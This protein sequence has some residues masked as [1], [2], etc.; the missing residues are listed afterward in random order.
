MILLD[1]TTKSLQ[2]ILGGAVTTT[3]LPIVAAYADV[4]QT[5][6]AVSAISETDTATTGGTAVTAVAAPSASTSRKVALVTVYN[7]D[8]VS[9]AVTV[10]VNNNGTFRIL[11]KATLAVGSTL[12]YADGA[13]WSVTDST[14]AVLSALS[15]DHGALSGLSDDDHTQYLLANGTRALTANWDVGSFEVRAQTLQSDVATG[16]APLIVASTTKVTNLNVDLLDDQSGA[17]YLDAANF[18]GTNW[19]DLTD[20]GATTLHKHDHGGS[21]GLADDDHTQYALLAGRSGGQTITGGTASGDDITIRSTTNATKGDIFLADQGGNVIIGGGATAS[22]V[23]LLEASGSGTNYTA[24]KTQPQ[25][26]N[27]TYTLP[28]D[29]GDASQ[30]LSTDG[31]G[32]LDWVTP[33]SG[34]MEQIFRGL[35]LRTSPNADVAA[36]T[37]AL[38]RCDAMTLDDGTYVEDWDDL[39]AII[40]GSGAGGLD[41]GAEAASTWYEIYAIRKS[42]DGTKN[43]LLHRAKDYFLDQQQ[44]DDD[45]TGRLREGAADKVKLAQTFDTDETGLC[46]FVDVKLIREG[47]VSG[48]V[49]FSI[50]ATSAGAPTGAALK[51]SDK[52]DASLI[53]TSVQI[54]RVPF[55]DPQTL[56]AGTTYALVLEG[57]YAVSGTVN[58]FWRADSTAPAYAAGQRYNFD[59]TSWAAVAEDFWFKIYITRNDAAVTMPSGYDQ[60]CKIGYVYNDSGSNF[61]PFVATDRQIRF[62]TETSLGTVTATIPTLIDGSAALPPGALL[63]GVYLKLTVDGYIGGVPDGITLGEPG[64]GGG[65][66]VAMDT[67]EYVP[68]FDI[69]TE[70]Q[71]FYA[72]VSSGTMTLR[73]E[74]YRW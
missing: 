7:A 26:A 1:A 58:I 29:D 10:R 23:R 2:V 6:F 44:T 48:R 63:A 14:G 5:T 46:E 57:D 68:P 19:T 59:G 20:T 50:Y 62:L 38:L 31:S 8:S 21:D 66:Y 37:V 3:E 74:G 28:A 49:W 27:I 9:A 41:T 73:I 11:V 65:V 70:Y 60:K 64:T 12:Q 39:S 15:V 53:S 43:L 25:A 45:T 13:G 67:A 35:H 18:T 4:S 52:I 17:Y 55:R 22:E 30:V 33:A 54:V 40:T 56:T 34:G 61:D 47:A 72:K 36:T 71:G 51:T 32:T 42:S 69:S 16:T 24:I